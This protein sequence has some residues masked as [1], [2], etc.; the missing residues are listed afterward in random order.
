MPEQKKEEKL[1][2]KEELPKKKFAITCGIILAVFI[3]ITIFAGIFNYFLTLT[4]IIAEVYGFLGITNKWI[5]L[6]VFTIFGFVDGFIAGWLFSKIYNVL[7]EYK[8]IPSKIAGKKLE[9]KEIKKK[10]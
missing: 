5:N 1:P 9:I 2:K 6:F 3:F 4:S 10:K 8:Y 7:L